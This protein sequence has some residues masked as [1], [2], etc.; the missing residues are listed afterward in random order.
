MNIRKSGPATAIVRSPITYT[1]EVANGGLPVTLTTVVITD[2]L[3]TGS[4]YVSGGT[5]VGDVISWTVPSLAVG[6]TITRQFVVTATETITNSDYG[7]S[8]S[9]GFS[10]T[11]SRSVVTLSLDHFVYLPIVMRE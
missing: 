8:A 10:A 6:E 3:P 2:V 11:A 9:E 7:V 4:S 5:L 1:L